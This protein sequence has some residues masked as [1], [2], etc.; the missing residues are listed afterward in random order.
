[1]KGVQDLE[2]NMV[3]LRSQAE[4]D[5]AGLEQKL[6][7]PMIDRAKKAIE[8]V[9]KEESFT[10]IFDTSTGVLLYMSGEDITPKVKAKLGIKS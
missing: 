10:Y 8:D 3:D 9:G 6:M 4:Q 5:L 1:M 2:Q 7:Q